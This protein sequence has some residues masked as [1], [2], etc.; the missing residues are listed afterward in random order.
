MIESGPGPFV[1]PDRVAEGYWCEVTGFTDGAGRKLVLATFEASTPRVAVH[2]TLARLRAMSEQF[3]PQDGHRVRSLLSTQE[4]QEAAMA[5]MVFGQVFTLTVTVDGVVY[6]LSAAASTGV[7]S[8]LPGRP[9]L[10]AR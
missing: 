3:D 7:E 4:D 2:W 6:V 5:E 9:L 10:V 8:R 1:V